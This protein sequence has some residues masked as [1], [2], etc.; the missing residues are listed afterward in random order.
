MLALANKGVE[1]VVVA[2]IPDIYK[3][4]EAGYKSSSARFIWGLYGICQS[5][6][7]NPGSFAQ[8]DVDRRARVRKQVDDFNGQLRVPV[9][10]SQ[11]QR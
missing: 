4:W 2:S 3:L 8:S 6:L 10:M 1:Q 5:M 11:I 9:Q 7:K